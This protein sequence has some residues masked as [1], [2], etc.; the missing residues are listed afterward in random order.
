MFINTQNSINL[1]Q[2][3]ISSPL[4][5]FEVTNLIGLNAPIFGYLNTTLTNLGLYSIF[6][7]ILVTGIHFMG[8]NE[9][10]LIPNK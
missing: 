5:Q 6:I 2:F 1:N 9:T 3:V 10:K 7:L 8:N 4:D